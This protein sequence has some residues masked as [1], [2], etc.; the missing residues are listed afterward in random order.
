MNF[1]A[2]FHNEMPFLIQLPDGDYGISVK[3]K[4]RD[5][6]GSMVEEVGCF[7]KDCCL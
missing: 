6:A 5:D 2:V 7:R 1:K 3:Y 4:K